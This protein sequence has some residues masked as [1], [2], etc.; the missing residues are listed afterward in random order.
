MS[1]LRIYYIYLVD[2]YWGHVELQGKWPRVETEE[3]RIVVADLY[4]D[5]L[6]IAGHI[7]VKHPDL[8]AHKEGKARGSVRYGL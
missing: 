8:R 5:V 2:V 3:V 4:Q 7:I 1:Y 6:S